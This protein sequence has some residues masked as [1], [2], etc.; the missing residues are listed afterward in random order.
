MSTPQLPSQYEGEQII[1]SS[2]RL[3]LNGRSDSIFL[4]ANQYVH[5]NANEGIYIDVGPTDTDD[6]VNK[7][8]INAPLIQLGDETKGNLQPVVKADDLKEILTDLFNAIN[9]TNDI[10][11]SSTK[12]PPIYKA[13]S[14][15]LKSQLAIILNK[16]DRPGF[17]KSN[18]TKTI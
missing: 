8:Y 15:Y 10:V 3:I 17:Y 2:G 12:I 13:G 18:I 14:S 5:I 1:L 4:S 9:T 6:I 7:L 11:L 16:L